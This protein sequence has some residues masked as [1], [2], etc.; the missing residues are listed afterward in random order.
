MEGVVELLV[1]GTPG[2]P[3]PAVNAEEL[4]RVVSTDEDVRAQFGDQVAIDPAKYGSLTD[5][6]ATV[7]RA[8]AVGMSRP[9]H[10]TY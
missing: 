10:R 2:E 8:M 3:V 6:G 9:H 4:Q 7:Y 5:P 1:F